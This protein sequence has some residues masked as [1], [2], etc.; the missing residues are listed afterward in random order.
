MDKEEEK[1]V[2]RNEVIMKK[3]ALMLKQWLRVVL[4][5]TR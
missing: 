5:M 4:S 2:G 3:I 1:K